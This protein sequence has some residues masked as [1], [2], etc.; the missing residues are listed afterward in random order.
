M[1]EEG[2]N[3]PWVG[4]APY[5]ASDE[6]E[7]RAV[8]TLE[9]ILNSSVKSNIDSRDKTPNHDGEVEIV[10]E[11][12]QPIGTLKVQVKKLPEKHRDEPKKQMN[13][14]HLTYGTLPTEQFLVVVVDTEHE[15]AYWKHITKKWMREE[16]N[17]G[18]QYKTVHFPKENIISEDDQSYVED[19]ERIIRSTGG[20]TE[21]TDHEPTPAETWPMFRGEPARTGHCDAE[22]GLKLD[23]ELARVADLSVSIKSSIGLAYEHLY[24]VGDDGGTLNV[25]GTNGEA[26]ALAEDT[27]NRTWTTEISELG[28]ST[29]AVVDGTL[30]VGGQDGVLY[31][32][33]AA[34][35]DQSWTFPTDD[36]VDTSPAVVDG[37]VYFGSGDGCV[38]ALD[39]TSGEQDWVFET[40]D[41]VDSSPAVDSGTVYVGNR[42]GNVYALDAGTGNCEWIFDTGDAVDTSPAVADGT[43][44]FGSEDK[45]VYA[46]DTESG[47]Q[48]WVFQTGNGVISSPAVA[49][50]MVFIGSSDFNVYA[51]D[52]STGDELW[53]FNTGFQVTASPIVVGNVVYAG[54]DKSLYALNAFTGEKRKRWQTEGMLRSSPSVADGTL[55]F[56]CTQGYVYTLDVD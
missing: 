44:Y 27:G 49:H 1:A 29:P 22:Y 18:Q 53:Q 8:D 15:V 40:S 46:V 20:A 16:V 41:W 19:W 36:S 47:D 11:E 26:Y 42:N 35:G 6:A 30:Y 55:Y 28:T 54:V 4:P 14:E 50:D 21:D 17:P 3:E 37:T 2:T 51:L 34:T 38:Y 45:R 31:A 56:G 5:P 33:D 32:L 9:Y 23:V 39:V 48:Q 43:V 7:H 12:D 13:V 10:N 52:A 24:V 25:M